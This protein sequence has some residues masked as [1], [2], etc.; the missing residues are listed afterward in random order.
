[1][2][3]GSGSSVGSGVVGTTVG[4]AGTSG[5]V[6]APGS[7]VDGVVGT[8]EGV[9]VGSGVPSEF[10]D[11]AMKAATAIPTSATNAR[12]VQTVP[13]TPRPPDRAGGD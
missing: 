13:A 5:A 9:V 12:I 6:V 7:V 11:A 4:S 8:T 10:D 2:G 3:S 1:V